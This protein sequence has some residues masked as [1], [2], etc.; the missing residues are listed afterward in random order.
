MG[1]M[2]LFKSRVIIIIVL[3][4][5]FSISGY[6]FYYGQ[7]LS[8]LTDNPKTCMN[9]HVMRDVFERWNHSSHKEVATCNGCH[10]PNKFLNKWFIKALNGWN[11]SRA[12]TTG[13]F[14]EPIRISGFNAKVV[15]QNCATCHSTLTSDIHKSDSKEGFTCIRCHPNTGHEK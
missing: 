2:S 12:F 14:N 4:I 11:H 15:E 8:Y 6:T 10:I 5:F 7:G 1:N 9:C 13:N 3:G